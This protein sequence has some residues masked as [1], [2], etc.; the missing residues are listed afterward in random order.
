MLIPKEI[1]V[2]NVASEKP[3]ILNVTSL[4]LIVFSFNSF[5]RSSGVRIFLSLFKSHTSDSV[6]KPCSIPK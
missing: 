2:F 4:Q 3:S 6:K 5:S 1:M